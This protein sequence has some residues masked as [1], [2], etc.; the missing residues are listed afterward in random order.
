MPPILGSGHS[1][2]YPPTPLPLIIPGPVGQ[3]E[4]L[5]YYCVLGVG[6]G[7][8]MLSYR[9]SPAEA[10]RLLWVWM[11]ERERAEGKQQS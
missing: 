8:Y 11:G 3:F 4:A 7:S 6:M 5:S 9:N 1:S 10:E 2:T